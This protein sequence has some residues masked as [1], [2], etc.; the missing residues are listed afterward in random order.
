M[1]VSGISWFGCNYAPQG[2]E[3]L[4]EVDSYYLKERLEGTLQPI[5]LLVE[6][7]PGFSLRFAHT[8][9]DYLGGSLVI[10]RLL[11]M[12]LGARRRKACRNGEGCR[13]VDTVFNHEEGHGQRSELV[14]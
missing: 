14:H 8:G 7:L 9:L 10:L 3:Q 1:P 13:T 11:F 4:G 2:F 12:P 6:Y 5:A